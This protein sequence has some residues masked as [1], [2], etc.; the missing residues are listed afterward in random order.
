MANQ[1]S[2]QGALFINGR[3]QKESHPD[4][5]GEITLST[6]LL[7]ELVAMTKSGKEPKIAIAGWNKKSKAGNQYISVAVQAFV[8]YDKSKSSQKAAPV[9]KAQED[10]ND[11]EDIPF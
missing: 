4:H 1:N 10:F 2:N 9:A 8:E 7:R 3:K 5:R 6:E 11:D